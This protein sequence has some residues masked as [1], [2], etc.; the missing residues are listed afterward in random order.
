MKYLLL[1]IFISILTSCSQQ[2]E[3]SDLFTSDS[4][5]TD[6]SGLSLNSLS[7]INQANQNAYVISGT[8][9][10]SSLVSISINS[11][12][13]SDST[14]CSASSFSLSMDL[15]TISDSSQVLIE[16]SQDGELDSFEVVKDSTIPQIN[17]V[18]ISDG[19]YGAGDIISISVD[20]TENIYSYLHVDSCRLHFVRF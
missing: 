4:L 7:K 5:G 1:L 12:E 2:G 15:S 19:S 17:S 10:G 6:E 14:D 13:V 16:I 11:T 20:F 18:S 3:D 8:C 9:V